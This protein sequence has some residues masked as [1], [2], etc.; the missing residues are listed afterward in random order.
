L[1]ATC[2]LIRLV[3]VVIVENFDPIWSTRT[4]LRPIPARQDGTAPRVSFPQAR[5][6]WLGA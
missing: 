1:T 5:W 4:A 6:P 3:A 2:L